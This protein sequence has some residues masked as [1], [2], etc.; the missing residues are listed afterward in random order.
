VQVQADRLVPNNRAGPIGWAP[1]SAP[2]GQR[3][4]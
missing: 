4:A 1:S 2:R 3:N